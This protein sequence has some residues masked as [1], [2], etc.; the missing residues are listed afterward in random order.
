ME[1]RM[2]DKTSGKSG[3]GKNVIFTFTK[4]QDDKTRIEVKIILN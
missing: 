4:H 2:N 3:K 1:E